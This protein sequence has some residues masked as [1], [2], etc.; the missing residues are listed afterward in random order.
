MHV[1]IYGNMYISKYVHIQIYVTYVYLCMCIYIYVYLHMYI[2]INYI[3]N[4]CIN[5]YTWELIKT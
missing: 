2:Y 4:V 5:V 1:N 3:I